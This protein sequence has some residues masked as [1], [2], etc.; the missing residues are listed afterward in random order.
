MIHR[1]ATQAAIAAFAC[2]IAISIAGAQ[3]TARTLTIADMRRLADV[4]DPH[5]SRDGEWVV[6]TV[7]SVDTAHDRSNGDIWLARWDGRQVTRMTWGTDDEHSPQFVGNT[8]AISF[9]SARGDMRDSDQLWLLPVDGGEARTLTAIKDGVA[10]YSW[11]PDGRRVVLALHDSTADADSAPHPIVLD[12]FQFKQDIEGYL[13]AHRVHLWLFDVSSKSLV[14]LTHG[15]HD[16]MMPEWSPDGTSILFSSKQQKDPDR[17]DN[18]DLYVIAPAPGAMPHQL[19]QNDLDDSD[20]QWE[21]RAVWSPDSKEI[22]FLQGGPDSLIYYSM[23]RLAVVSA[24][25]GPVRVV[26]RSLDRSFVHPVWSADGKWIYAQLEDDGSMILARVSNAGDNVERVLDGRRS[27]AAVAAG[28]SHIAIVQSTPTRPDELFAIDG[29]SAR[30]LTDANPWLRDVRLADQEPIAAKSKDGTIIHGFLMRPVGG[31]AREPFPTI[32]RLHGGPVSEWENGFE[33]SWQMLAAHGFAVVGM[34]PRGSSGRGLAWAKTIY[35]HWGEKDVDDVLSG[36]DHLVARRIA[37]PRRLGV[38]GWS[39]GAELTDYVIASDMR[40]KAAVS[41]A[42]IG[43]VLAGFGTDQYVREYTAEL[44]VPWTHLAAWLR[45]SY[46][47]LHADRIVTPTLFMAGDLDY[48][49]PLQNSEQMYQALRSLGVESELVIYP[50]EHHGLT[51]PS[52]LADRL[53]RYIAWYGTH[54]GVK[55]TDPAITY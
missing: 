1:I 47:F 28:G 40:F 16:D 35:A 49:V 7:S 50:G 53:S 10:D 9:L 36:V 48:N 20:P 30:Q 12:R 39:Y 13:D 6:Y 17:T 4:S 11:S 42:G 8:R 33:L 45:V 43:N 51:R 27:I 18:W 32:L 25:G 41:G 29:D 19:T 15:D 24:A 37:D 55:S 44:G 2:L 14:Q 26:S 46:P 5:V 31:D 21:S 3:G 54:L 52:F 22:A 34:N 23:Q 38:G